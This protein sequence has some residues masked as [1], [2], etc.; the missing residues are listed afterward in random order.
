M[1][2]KTHFVSA[3]VR[4]SLLAGGTF[5]WLGL[6]PAPVAAQTLSGFFSQADAADTQKLDAG[7]KKTD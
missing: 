7:G 2:A 1:I 5:T 6:L 3:R 4:A